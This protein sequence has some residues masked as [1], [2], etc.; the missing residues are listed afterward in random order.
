MAAK[1]QQVVAD[2]DYKRLLVV[3]GA[4]HLSGMQKILESK[5]QPTVQKAV[6]T[7]T[8][9]ETLPAESNWPKLIPWLIVLLIVG[10]FVTGFQKS[11]EMGW[12]MVIDWVLINGSLSALGALI[13]FAHPL[14]IITAF[15]AAPLTSLN[16]TIGAGMVTG[17]LDAWLCKPNVEDFQ[18]LKTD[19]THLKGW[20]KNRVARVLLVFL[21]S[22]LGSAVGTYIAGFTIFQRLAG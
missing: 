5:P 3:I 17:A 2:N 7:I 22:S 21:L 1:I 6:D 12:K 18:Q 16:P 15:L 10:G 9:L 4:G 14:T 19:I 20:W 8:E 13:A 11:P